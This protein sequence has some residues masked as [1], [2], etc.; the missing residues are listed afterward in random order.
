M[1]FRDAWL[2]VGGIILV[3]GF[4]AGEPIIAGVGA[5]ILLVGGLSRYWSR[6][7]FSRVTLTRTLSER[8]TFVDEPVQLDVELENRKLLPLPWFE[9]R[10][11]LGDALDAE[12]ESLAAS[13][14]PGL[15]W[16]V[17][18]GAIGWYEHQRWRFSLSGRERGYHQVGPA[19]IRSA[20]LLGVFP[21]RTEDLVSDHLVVY[22]KLIALDGLDLPAARPLG[23][24][25]GLDRIFEDPLRIAG[26]RDYRP[27]DSLRRIDWKA[28]ARRGELQ[29]RV[30]EPS[31]APHLYLLL[32]IDTLAHAWEGYLAGDLERT[33]STAATI[34]AWA[35]EKRFAI[36]LLANGSYPTADRPIRLPPSRARDQLPRVM[37]ALAVVQPLTMGDLAGAILREKGRWPRGSTIVLVAALLPPELAASVQ[38]LRDEGHHVSVVA[39]SDRVDMSLVRDIPLAQRVRAFAGMKA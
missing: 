18:R 7:L 30:Y 27:G 23:D 24:R 2:V 17:R 11:A 32:N 29:S 6:H 35:A 20:D 21:G 4:A 28:T 15:S 19:S 22:P 38:R 34:A 5:A 13:A 37:E 3:A 39:T 10:I 26:L 1:P 8:R 9:W 14:A 36:G 16:L 25:R 12:G 31:A 33:V